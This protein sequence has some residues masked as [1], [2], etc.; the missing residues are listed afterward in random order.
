MTTNGQTKPK[1]ALILGSGF[2]RA[3]GLPTAAE[4]GTKL[5]QNPQNGV[6]AA[7]WEQ[8]ISDI[9]LQFWQDIFGYTEG[10]TAPSLEDHFTMLD[11][12]A[13]S[14][15]NLGPRYK[16]KVLRAI[17]RMSIHRVFQ[18]LEK[19][20]ISHSSVRKDFFER[21][22]NTF[23]VAVVTPNWDIV[24]EVG[25]GF[26]V[27]YGIDVY[28][29]DEPFPGEARTRLLKLHGS[30]NWVY[31]DCCRRIYG[32]ADKTALNMG[33]FL[34]YDDFRLFDNKLPP[35]IPE[36]FPRGDRR[37]SSCGNELGGRIAT[38]SYRKDFS[39]RQ[40]QTIW[41][42]AY[43]ALQEAD[44]WLVIGYS[45]PQ[46]DFE[47]RHLLKSAQLGRSNPEKWT[48]EVV[49]KTDCIAQIQFEGLFGATR[50]RMEQQGLIKW[51]QSRLP[52]LLAEG[53]S[54]NS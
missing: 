29:L 19:N 6:L 42:Q 10:T 33:V 4:L 20:L 15:H 22:Q 11:L 44:R 39:I 8:R 16:P 30:A 21:L 17:R 46:A 3:F 13:N 27:N 34:E 54:T 12:S 47:L 31:C 7:A 49:L 51:I 18:M 1:L 41:Q 36:D 40:F 53:V 48:C 9:L 50:I 28:S 32:G 43:A 14:G 45:L 2:S 37:C 26:D 38:F 35:E 25:L 23:D 5:L 24:A 52:G